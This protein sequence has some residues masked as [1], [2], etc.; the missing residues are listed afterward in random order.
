MQ[1]PCELIMPAATAGT[2]MFGKGLEAA[3]GERV[4]FRKR[5]GLSRYMASHPQYADAAPY[6][7]K[8]RALQ[9]RA[10]GSIRTRVQTV[11]KQAVE[12]AR[13]SNCVSRAIWAGVS[14]HIREQIDSLLCGPRQKLNQE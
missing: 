10:M 11:L 14:L 8:F 2:N 3:D 12:Q 7:G 13:C 5:V 9:Q 6:V 4:K 1:I